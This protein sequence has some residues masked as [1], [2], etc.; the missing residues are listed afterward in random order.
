MIAG[1]STFVVVALFCGALNGFVV[2]S[3]GVTPMLATLGTM[4]LFEGIC[5]NITKGGAI[6]GFPDSF[7]WFGSA[8]I[9][10]IPFPLILFALVVVAGYYLMERSPF[11]LKAYMI[12]CSPTVTAYSGINVKRILYGIY[13]FSAVLCAL[14]GVLMSSRYNSAKESYGSSYLMQSISAAVL[15]GTDIN[16]GYGKIAGTVIAV[17]ILQ[18]ISSGLDIFGVNRYIV[19]VIMG[20]ILILVLAINFFVAKDKASV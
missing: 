7:M 14:A 3:I 4:T 17:M 13:L 9:L 8:T 18:V 6:S 2:A 19:N 15:G 1:L 20:G 10:G 11:G 12:G 5:L 16:G